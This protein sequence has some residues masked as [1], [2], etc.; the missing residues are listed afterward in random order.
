MIP[1]ND[2]R[3]KKCLAACF[4]LFL[5][6]VIVIELAGLGFELPGLRPLIV[7]FF[8]ALVPGILILRILK[9]HNIGLLESLLNSIGFS[10]LLI[11]FIGIVLNFSLP[12]LGITRPISLAPL[13]TGTTVV[14]LILA[15]FAY[16]RDKSFAPTRDR[17]TRK[18]TGPK[19]ERSQ[20]LSPFLLA[21]LLP[22]LSVLGAALAYTRQNDVLLFAL[23][24]T[25]AIIVGLVTFNRFIPSEAYPLMLF[26]I[27]LSLFY[28]TT[29]FSPYLIGSDIHLE[30][31]LAR[32]VLQNGYWDASIA[33]SVNSC[34]SIVM[35]TPFHSLFLGLD[36]IWLFKIIYPLFFCLVPL[37]LYRVFSSQIGPR[38]AFLSAFFFISLPMFFMDMPQLIRQQ[39]SELFFVLIMLLVVDRKLTMVQRTTMI[40]LFGLGVMVSYYGL[41]TGYAVGYITCGLLLLLLL[42]S[43]VGKTAWQW[44]VRK[45]N[46]LPDD[47]SLKGAFNKKSLF[48]I[49]AVNLVFMILY[50]GFVASGAAAGGMRTITEITPG[51]GQGISSA[52]GLTTSE[53]LI[54]TALGLDFIMASTGGKIWRVLQY[55]VEL[56]FVLGFLRLVFKPKSLG[57]LKTEYVAFVVVSVLILGAVF[58]LPALSYRVNTYN[59]Y[60]MGITR[61][62]Q[63]T[64]LVLSPLFIFGGEM[65]VA[66]IVRLWRLLS[67]GLSTL[68]TGVNYQSFLWFPVIVVLIPYFLFNSGVVFELSRNRTTEFIDVPYSITLS[69]HRVD[70]NTVFTR[71]DL[72]AAHW[73]CRDTIGNTPVY[74]DH[75]GSK[76]FIDQIEFPC[77]AKEVNQN[78]GGI[79]APG[80]FYLRSWNIGSGSLTFPTG[81]ATRQSIEFSNLSWFTPVMKDSGRIYNS[82][83]SQILILSDFN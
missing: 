22:L 35:V 12:P 38:Y 21:I 68:R 43:R 3:I 59:A 80:Y 54:R 75:H 23:I 78:A 58:L 46:S 71:Q 4:G 16:Q 37:G 83:G 7:L 73:L 30:D 20:K 77:S 82:G 57:K 79:V 9:I 45:S 49:I 5:A 69:S 51:G 27:A 41:G 52:L 11:I 26:M 32:V 53:P 55:L 66:G 60:G 64:L 62:W 42:K 13:L 29:L 24:F 8:V 61:V 10:L 72:A 63:I 2:W 47:L 14:C 25:I 15:F 1:P 6:T 56:C 28:Q 18:G 34:L 33:N 76:L 17:V 36:I 31:Y 65:I 19:T 67:R 70:V 40:I 39:F 50:Y 81:Y 48:T 74:T 44:L